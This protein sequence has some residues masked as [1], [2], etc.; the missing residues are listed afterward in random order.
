M[1]KEEK[2]TNG[3]CSSRSPC[4]V[5]EESKKS[6]NFDSMTHGRLTEE[7]GRFISGP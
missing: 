2:T 3:P 7:L 6:K 5:F 4:V 1:K